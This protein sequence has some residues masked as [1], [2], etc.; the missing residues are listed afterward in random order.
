MSMPPN[1]TGDFVETAD[2]EMAVRLATEVIRD[3]T[4]FSTEMRLMAAQVLVSAAGLV[5]PER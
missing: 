5:R 3:E 4:L 2:V 1:V